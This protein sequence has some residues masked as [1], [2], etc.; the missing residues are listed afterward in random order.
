MEQPGPGRARA[1][2]VACTD[3][4][5]VLYT[6]AYWLSSWDCSCWV[7]PPPPLG[8]K[9][10]AEVDELLAAAGRLLEGRT[11][12]LFGDFTVADVDLAFAL[13]RLRATGHDLDAALA[14][15]ADR[16]WNRPSVHEYVSHPR[17]PHV[18]PEDRNTR[19]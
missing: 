15:Y 11:R 17:P 13:Q 19:R 16:V 10:R 1:T 3:D 5:L 14:A 4:P 7:T 18:P 8:A 12:F 2:R 9:A 6:G